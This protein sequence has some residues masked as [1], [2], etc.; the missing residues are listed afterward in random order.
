MQIGGAKQRMSDVVLDASA[1]LC[2]LKR[3]QGHVRVRQVV[4]GALVS[5]VNWSEVIAKLSELGASA[6]EIQGALAL[7]PVQLIPFDER[8]ARRAGLLRRET[9]PLG[10]SFGDRACLALAM[11]ENKVAVTT[12]RD[13]RGVAGVRTEFVR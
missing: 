2:L 9:K 5:V 7:F 10:L 12:D 1:L 8:L 6:D 3:E 11:T 4:E 13:W